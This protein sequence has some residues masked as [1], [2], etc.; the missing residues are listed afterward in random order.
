MSCF[1]KAETAP[2][3][4]TIV[5]FG[6]GGQTGWHFVKHALDAGYHVR[7]CVRNTEALAKK[8][9]AQAND[10][11]LELFPCDITNAGQVRLLPSS[12]GWDQWR[13]LVIALI[14][15]AQVDKAITKGANAVVSFIGHSRDS[16]PG[17]CPA[18]MRQV[19]ESSR[20]VRCHALAARGPPSRR[21]P[22]C[23]A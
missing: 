8:L 12:P 5:V 22:T 18:F 11:H 10:S 7:A 15:H 2:E 20:K 19:L 3:R 6:A 23:D 14:L 9:G 16:R 13:Q 21:L 17:M 1:G 4:Q